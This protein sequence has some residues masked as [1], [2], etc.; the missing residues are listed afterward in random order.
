M[1]SSASKARN[2]LLG[3][4]LIANKQAEQSPHLSPNERSFFESLYW[5][6]T[7]EQPVGLLQVEGID[8]SRLDT[9]VFAST[10]PQ[11]FYYTMAANAREDVQNYRSATVEDVEDEDDSRSSIESNVNELEL[12][13]DIT[14][15]P[16]TVIIQ[17]PHPDVDVLLE[18]TA[19][20]D[21]PLTD[22]WCFNEDDNHDDLYPRLL[23]NTPWSANHLIASRAELENAFNNKVLPSRTIPM[24][25]PAWPEDPPSS[26]QAANSRR[27]SSLSPHRPPSM[28]Q[29]PTACHANI[30]DPGPSSQMRTAEMFEYDSPLFDHQAAQFQ[31][32]E[33]D[34]AKID[35]DYANDEASP[36]WP[37]PGYDPLSYRFGET[38]AITNPSLIMKPFVPATHF[39]GAAK[40][41]KVSGRYPTEDVPMIA[42]LSAAVYEAEADE[43]KKLDK[44]KGKEK[45]VDHDPLVEVA[46]DGDGEFRA[47]QNTIL[48]DIVLRR[49]NQATE[50]G[51]LSKYNSF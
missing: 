4:S 26:P 33:E 44:R 11:P 25:L 7:S 15:E 34:L 19:R 47:Y 42:A 50:S 1:G 13:F 31:F 22:E 8:A 29:T 17:E 9:D 6:R 48:N 20:S 32:W 21:S 38:F 16:E 35:A 36:T 2:R 5:D 41:W 3:G 24:R 18:T 30:M 23:P 46:D 37:P 40:A 39:P 27:L 49:L 12:A 51:V 10:I 28:V 14:D 43:G 45:A